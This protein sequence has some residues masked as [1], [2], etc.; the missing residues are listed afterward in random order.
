[1]MKRLFKKKVVGGGK[2]ETLAAASMPGALGVA[3]SSMPVAH[4]SA[5]S[6]KKEGG[7]E[8]WRSELIAL[9]CVHFVCHVVWTDIYHIPCPSM[10]RNGGVC[11]RVA[12]S[13]TGGGDRR[14]LLLEQHV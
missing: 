6:S 1:M 9:L 2:E 7:G 3:P 14:R 10:W 8:R 12:C 13:K 4:R 11:V 5:G